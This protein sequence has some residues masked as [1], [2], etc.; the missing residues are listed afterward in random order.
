M[1]YAYGV[2]RV[3][4]QGLNASF[5]HLAAQKLFGEDVSIVPCDVFA[6]CFAAVESGRAD[7][8]VVAVENSLYG[9][10][11]PVYDLLLKTRTY[12][13][14]ETYLRI[15][16]CLIGIQG[17]PLEAITEVHSQVMALAQCEEFLDGTLPQ[18]VRIEE[19]DTTASVQMVANW[20]DPTK[21]AIAGAEAAEAYGLSVLAPSIE[22]NQE[23]YTRFIVVE[24]QERPV[25][26]AT[27]TSLVLRMPADTKAGSLFHALG[28][29]AARNINMLL[30]HSRPVAETAW[31]YMF[32]IDVATGLQED[33][34]SSAIHELQ[35]QGCRVTVLGSYPNG[36]A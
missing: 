11:N 20:N 34:L 8:A 5:H 27:K 10:I 28:V 6:D 36:Q 14:A 32:Y 35:A 24:K 18:A 23:N 15:H 33:S 21:A 1:W 22:T 31:H 4:I 30:L 9:S 7:K 29:F 13:T 25:P 17:S 26:E 2:M 16:Q 12:I 19:H 3:A